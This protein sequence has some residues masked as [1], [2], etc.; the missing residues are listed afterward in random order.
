[1]THLD[2]FDP[3]ETAGVTEASSR[4][5][6]GGP[7][8]IPRPP[9][10]RLGRPAPWHHLPPARR[11][12]SLDTIVNLVRDAPEPVAWVGTA[13]PTHR[14]PSAVLVPLYEHEGEPYVILTRRAWHLRNHQGEV[15]FPGGRLDPGETIHEA[16]LREADE[17]IA[18][19]SS[20]AEVV[21]ELDHLVT[22]TSGASIAPVVAVLPGQPDLIPSPAEVDA[23]LH[24]RLHEFLAL[25]VYREE[26]WDW[27]GVAR[28]LWFFELLGDTVWGATAA[29]LRNLLAL[30]T[31]VRSGPP[32]AGRTA[33]QR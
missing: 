4:L 14:R 15:S 20:S 32:Y 28:P 29:I 19:D 31:G 7:Q 1:M 18:L 9:G 11:Q 24:V 26:L 30:S 5:S 27:E 17:E 13:P 33:S 12:P 10:H 21:G 16:A 8:H 25:D 22:F 2:A 6:R 3:D 23:I